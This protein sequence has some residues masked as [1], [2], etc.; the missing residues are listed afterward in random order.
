MGLET[1]IH[2]GK[3]KKASLSYK[4]SLTFEDEVVIY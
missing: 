3:Y 1:L 2:S 4:Y